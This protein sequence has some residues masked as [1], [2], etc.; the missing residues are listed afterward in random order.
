MPAAAKSSV[1]SIDN[2]N[3]PPPTMN[4]ESRPKIEESKTIQISNQMKQLLVDEKIYEP[5]ISE[6]SDIPEEDGEEGSVHLPSRNL[7]V[8][9]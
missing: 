5:S 4:I 8:N 1:S 9:L 2:L 6:G 3:K 7:S